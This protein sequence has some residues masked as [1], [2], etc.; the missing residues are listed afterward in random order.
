VKGV[1]EA[2]T[3]GCT[4]C[5][6][7]AVCDALSPLGVHN[8]D[9]PLKPEL[10][11]RAMQAGSKPRAEKIAPAKAAARKPQRAGAKKRRRA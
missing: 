10:V 7:N 1:G 2:G 11:W 9:M 5:I 6:V 8:L 4:P 3:I